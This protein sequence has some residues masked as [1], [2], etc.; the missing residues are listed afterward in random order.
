MCEQLCYVSREMN[1]FLEI[2]S[3]DES[4]KMLVISKHETLKLIHAFSKLNSFEF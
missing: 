4:S 3:S 2:L 1:S